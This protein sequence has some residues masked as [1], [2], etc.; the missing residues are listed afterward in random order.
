MDLGVEAAGGF[1]DFHGAVVDGGQ[2]CRG[3]DGSGGALD[4]DFAVVHEEDVGGGRGEFFEVVGDEQHGGR[5]GVV[6]LEESLNRGQD[7]LAGEEIEAGG[8]FVEL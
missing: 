2:V 6:R 5:G 7:L 8:G 4:G 3:E 1:R